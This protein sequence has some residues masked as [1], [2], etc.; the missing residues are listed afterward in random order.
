[1]GIVREEPDLKTQLVTEICNI[2]RC[3]IACARRHGGNRSRSPFIDWY[4]ILRVE[5]NAGLDV[6]RKQYHR[7]AL[8]LHPDKNK[9]PKAE[10]AFKLVSEAY[11]CLSQ[12][13]KRAEFNL[14]RQSSR[15][16]ECNRGPYASSNA[17]SNHSAATRG[18]LPTERSSQK[19]KHG[20]KDLRTRFSEEI[21]VIENCLRATKA[22]TKEFSSF[23]TRKEH[24]IFNPS[25]YRFTGYPHQRTEGYTR[26]PRAF[27]T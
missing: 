14:E 8:Q 27:T 21:K 22:A 7:L 16:I 19:N 3:A 6:I 25:D 24:P 20:F 18:F 15:C 11:E 4:L 1:M 9:H 23:N 12:D 5:E 13:A 10:V 17:R 26:N 2:S